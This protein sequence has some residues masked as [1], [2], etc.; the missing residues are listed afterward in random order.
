MALQPESQLAIPYILHFLTDAVLQL[1][2]GALEGL[3]R[4]P[5]T[6]LQIDACKELL[7][8]GE[9]VFDPK[10]SA[11]VVTSLLK[12]WL[13]SLSEPIVPVELYHRCLATV[14]KPRDSVGIVDELPELNK[15]VLKFM[16]TWLQENILQ[17]EIQRKTRMDISSIAMAFGPCFLS[18]PEQ[19]VEEMVK[20]IQA[21]NKFTVNLLMLMNSDVQMYESKVIHLRSSSKGENKRSM[22]TVN[23]KFKKWQ[24]KSKKKSLAAHNIR[25]QQRHQV[26]EATK[27]EMLARR[28]RT[29]YNEDLKE[30]TREKEREKEKKRAFLTLTQSSSKDSA[31]DL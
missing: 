4:V 31:K 11:H 24:D 3:F 13:I 28:K 30:L 29:L 14:A 18:Y 22:N 27:E 2:G 23:D 25:Q 1:G 12:E 6:K 21:Q 9:Y 7:N 26:S 16:V 19:R 17:P 20:N 5:G 15:R 10:T 8:K